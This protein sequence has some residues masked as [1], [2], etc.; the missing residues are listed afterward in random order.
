LRQE[1][2]GGGG[3]GIRARHPTPGIPKPVALI[4]SDTIPSSDR[5]NRQM[6]K[7]RSPLPSA[8]TEALAKLGTDLKLPSRQPS[9]A[10]IL[11]HR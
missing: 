3:G 7:V 1:E 8:V 11:D 5:V 4:I 9:H 6:R 10:G 2:A